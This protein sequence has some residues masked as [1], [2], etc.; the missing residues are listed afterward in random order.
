MAKAT[1][2]ATSAVNCH[3][4]TAIL[5]ILLLWL[6]A[7]AL[8]RLCKRLLRSEVGEGLMEL[9]LGVALL[10]FVFWFYR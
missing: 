1:F 10:A 9:G 8:V 6:L 4:L 5:A 2:I 7:V 3:L